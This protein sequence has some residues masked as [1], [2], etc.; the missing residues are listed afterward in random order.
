MTDLPLWLGL[1]VSVA[2]FLALSWAILLL[3][4]RWVRR[5]SHGA[6]E[7]DRVLGYVT[8]AYGVLYGVTLAMI[9]AAAFSHSTDVDD[10]VLRESSSV[11]VLYRDASGFGEPTASE[12]RQALAAYTEDVVEHDWPQQQAGTKPEE[13]RAE[14]DEIQRLLFSYEPATA[15][16]QQVQ[17]QAIGAFN[18]F[19]ADRRERI[20]ITGLALPSVLWVVVLVGAVLNAV[21][22]ALVEV[23]NLRA[24]LIMS[25]LIAAY[26]ALVVYAIATFDSPYSGAVAVGPGYF[27]DLLDGLFAGSRGAGG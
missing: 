23:R 24:H 2:G 5:A 27:V 22:I 21:L 17:N 3:L 1:L 8:A 7:W 26:V 14:I 18:Q 11:A 9:A 6:P 20:A 13:A 25:G 15:G 16:Q 19:V 10:I 4:R 12:L